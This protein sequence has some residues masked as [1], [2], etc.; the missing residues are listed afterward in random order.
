MNTRLSIWP[1]SLNKQ[2]PLPL[3]YQLKERI[4]AHIESGNLQTDQKLPS[5]TKLA[6]FHAI[7]RMTARRTLEELENEGYVH[8]SHG[9]GTFVTEPKLRQSLMALTSFSEDMQ[10][11]GLQPGARLVNADVI[12][13]PSIAAKLDI[14]TEESLV[15][16]QRVRLA[17]NTP[18]ALE[19]SFLRRDICPG[20]ETADLED[21]SL[22]QVLETEH[23]VQLGNAEQT[24]EAK[25]ADEYEAKSLEIAP[26][27][28]VLLIE[29]LTFLNDSTT[30]IELVISTYRADRYKF[31]IQLTRR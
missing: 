27:S 23:D 16:I 8:R 30:P 20:I 1:A 26:G 6:E 31:Y 28:P 5:E 9:R 25:L 4:K 10:L 29:R 11:R 2:D 18:M 22:Y 21:R 19:T 3:Y 24:H 12:H 7:S 15:E 13:N 14:P 17:N